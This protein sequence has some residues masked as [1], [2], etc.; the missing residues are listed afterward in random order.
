[1]ILVADGALVLKVTEI[2]ADSVMGACVS[3]TYMYQNKPIHGCFGS[4][5]GLEY[6]KNYSID[7]GCPG[8][9]VGWLVRD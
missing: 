2:K 6:I 9:L 1:M 7:G 5:V 3:Q 8:W 4:L